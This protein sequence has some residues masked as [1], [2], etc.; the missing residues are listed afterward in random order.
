MLRARVVMRSGMMPVMPM[1]MAVMVAGVVRAGRGVVL[2]GVRASAAGVGG[3]DAGRE[4]DREGDHADGQRKE[5]LDRTNEHRAS[6]V[7]AGHGP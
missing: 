3:C 1:V 7:V 5:P 6:P 4:Q 2:R